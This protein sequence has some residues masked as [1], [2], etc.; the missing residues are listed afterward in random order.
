VEQSLL[1]QANQEWGCVVAMVVVH[2][3]W[4]LAVL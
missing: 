4:I 1:D 3:V 2:D